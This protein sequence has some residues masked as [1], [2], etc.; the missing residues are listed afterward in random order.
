MEKVCSIFFRTVRSNRKRID[1]NIGIVNGK[2]QRH[3]CTTVI[4]LMS[5]EKKKLP[6][7]PVLLPPKQ[8]SIMMEEKKILEKEPLTP[9]IALQP[10]DGS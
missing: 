2:F 10:E 6:I 9:S 3:T 1:S 7:P 8:P 5:V 4:K